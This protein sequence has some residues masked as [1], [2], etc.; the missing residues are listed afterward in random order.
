MVSAASEIARDVA[1][2]H[3]IG[4]ST[5]R[6]LGYATAPPYAVGRSSDT[7]HAIGSG[8]RATRAGHAETQGRR[9]E[10]TLPPFSAS[11]RMTCP[12]S[13]TFMPALSFGLPE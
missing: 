8:S 1:R 9:S 4:V 2:Q 11:F 3:A 10:G 13:Q 6:G 7:A 12:C 5:A